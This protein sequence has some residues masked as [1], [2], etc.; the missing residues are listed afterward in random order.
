MRAFELAVVAAVALA[1]QA[2]PPP[3]K[4]L[5]DFAGTRSVPA[6]LDEIVERA[7]EGDTARAAALALGALAREGELAPTEL[8]QAE[9]SYALGV[10]HTRRGEGPAAQAAFRSARALAGPGEL[11]LDATY[12]LGHFQ[13]LR[14]EEH[15]AEL[16]QP[17]AAAP[18][19]GPPGTPGAS[20]APGSTGEDGADPLERARAAYLRARESFVERLRSDWRDPD[21]R[22]NLEL[23]VRRLKELDEIERQREEQEQQQEPSESDEPSDDQQE[24]Q[25]EDEEGQDQQESGDEE[26]SG[27]EQQPPQGEGESP[28]PQESPETPEAPEPT[29]GPPP[30]EGQ[31]ERRMSREEVMRLLDRLQDLEEEAQRLEAMLQEGRRIPVERDW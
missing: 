12:N 15:R 16:L 9:L 26:P 29:E 30:A 24:S 17:A 13:L 31:A 28:E 19:G 27:Q 23:I 2:E 7:D 22:A 14:G 11:R 18:P 3:E 4:A 1:L 25:G 20:G 10:V 21:T 8:E 5:A 6:L